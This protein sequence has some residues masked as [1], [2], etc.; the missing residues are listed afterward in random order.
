[1]A[2][3]YP[4]FIPEAFAI[5]ANPAH[6]NTIPANPLTTQRA[7]WSLGYPPQTMQPVVAGG[8]PM[9]GPDMNGVL[10]AMSSHAVYAQTGQPYRWNADVVVAI[11]GYAAGTLLGSTDTTTLWFNLADGNS[12]D[13]DSGGAANWTPMYSYGISTVSGLNGGIV[14]LTAAQAKRNVI[15]L[16]GALVSNLQIVLPNSLRRW[17]IVNTTSGAF[18]TTVRTA[19]G[20]GVQIPQGGF[21]APTE[22]YGDGT[23]IYNVVAP[24]SLPIDVAPS[25][26]TIAQ[27]SNA[28]YLYATYFNQNSPQENFTMSSVF[29]EA[30]NDGFHRKIHPLN[31]QAQLALSNFGGQVSNGQV[32]V[33]AVNQYRGTILN[34]SALTGTPTAPTQPAGTNNTTVATTAFVQ[35]SSVLSGN[36]WM[37]WPNG[38]LMQWGYATS[39]TYQVPVAFPVAFSAIFFLGCTTNRTTSSSEGA[40]YAHSQSAGGCTFIMDSRAGVGGGFGGW[41]LAIG[42]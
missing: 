20:T 16:S 39:G 14:T 27:R 1:M 4:V 8:K 12:T 10:Y 36:G 41:W 9:L 19:G 22:V 24:V 13:P 2:A 29:A 18:T 7:S 6:R 42:V 34:N 40:N 28:G 15:V 30:G 25:A 37:R 17:L 35:G 23:N 33:G 32:P 5:D 3:P 38:L 21:G 11:A 26:N 31:F